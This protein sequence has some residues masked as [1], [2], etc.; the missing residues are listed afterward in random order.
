M[1]IFQTG[2]MPQVPFLTV[3][4]D[5]I[6]LRHVLYEGVSECSGRYV[7]QDVKCDDVTYRRLVFLDN[8]TIVQS[9]AMLKIQG[10]KPNTTI[11]KS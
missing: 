9:E 3:G 11:T 10:Q 8:R 5:N 7:V 6:N 4:G 2:K 1:F